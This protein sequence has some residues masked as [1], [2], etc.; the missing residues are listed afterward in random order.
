M[1]NNTLA[2]VSTPPPSPP[3]AISPALH[4]GPARHSLGDGSLGT[5]STASDMTTVISPNLG[6]ETSVFDPALLDIA[7]DSPP[8][9]AS[10]TAWL[11]LGADLHGDLCGVV[12]SGIAM[13][14]VS[15]GVQE[16][17]R[18]GDEGVDGVYS[19]STPTN[20]ALQQHDAASASVT[21][22]PPARGVV[23]GAASSSFALDS[24]GFVLGQSSI[25]TAC[26]T[27]FRR[28]DLALGLQANVDLMALPSRS[29]NL[30]LGSSRIDATDLASG[31]EILPES[32]MGYHTQQQLKRFLQE[33]NISSRYHHNPSLPEQHQQQR[34]RQLYQQQHPQQKVHHPFHPP[35]A[36]DNKGHQH[37]SLSVSTTHHFRYPHTPP[38]RRASAAPKFVTPLV[39]DEMN[40]NEYKGN[41][42][43]N[44]SNSHSNLVLG[45]LDP[46]DPHAM[47][48]SSAV[49]KTTRIF[50]S[51]IGTGGVDE[52]IDAAGGFSV[53][54]PAI[55]N[56]P[57][58]G[59]I[60]AAVPTAAPTRT[61]ASYARGCYGTSDSSSSSGGNASTDSDG[62][63]RSSD[64]G[65][66]SSEERN[67]DADDGDGGDDDFEGVAGEVE[68]ATA[69]T[70][71]QARW[72]VGRHEG[73]VVQEAGARRREQP[74]NGSQDVWRAKGS[75]RVS[76]R[77]R[78]R[79]VG[80]RGRGGRR[81]G[82]RGAGMGAIPAVACVL[83]FAPLYCMFGTS[84][85]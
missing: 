47:V 81:G 63:K 65:K 22:P 27:A 2:S 12:G 83:F 1:M 3:P 60:G 48:T 37:S 46:L 18:D 55:V 78:G 25:I 30:G 40:G 79:W 38:F 58:S 31:L 20:H 5:T 24:K 57:D 28:D 16:L 8:T 64:S 56:A 76:S 85:S 29:T 43:N 32:D 34:Q 26:S 70:T 62:D 69:Q 68:E 39:Y 44:S 4:G 23:G 75:G 13:L 49:G 51:A 67:G 42:N 10:P 80:G 72:I 6:Y 36:L 45:R 33:S 50:T 7:C 61:A 11:T 52:A 14:P 77:G 54:R 53:G 19:L 35:Q 71:G 66:S 41:S 74:P 82:G 73:T 9:T 15:S 21:P 84:C 59:A 17:Q